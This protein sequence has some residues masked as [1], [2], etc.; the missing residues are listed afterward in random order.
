[1]DFHGF[2]VFM[3]IMNGF[4]WIF[5]D[6]LSLLEDFHGFSWISRI[7]DDSFNI[8][9][10]HWTVASSPGESYLRNSGLTKQCWLEKKRDDY[11]FTGFI[12]IYIHICINIYIYVYIYV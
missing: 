5:M 11:G 3:T 8:P 1:M 2:F 9:S 4:S 10:R 12:Y 6:F 7:F